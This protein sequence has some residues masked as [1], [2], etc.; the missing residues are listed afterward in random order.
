MNV[1]TSAILLACTAAAAAFALTLDEDDLPEV[2]ADAVGDLA[3][4]LSE[5]SAKDRTASAWFRHASGAKDAV[6]V[7]NGSVL[8]KDGE[9]VA[10]A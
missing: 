5:N 8:L 1:R 10:A 6:K 3:D 2:E 9:S 7:E 4:D